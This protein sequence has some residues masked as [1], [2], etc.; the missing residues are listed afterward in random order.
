MKSPSLDNLYA[1]I[2]RQI[3]LTES[4]TEIPGLSF[5]IRAC[6]LKP[7]SY[8]YDEKL[9][10]IVLYRKWFDEFGNSI[11]LVKKKIEIR[12]GDLS[13]RN[14]HVPCTDLYYGLSID[15]IAKMSKLVY[16]FAGKESPLQDCYLLAFLGLDNYLRAYM[17][18]YGEWQR[19]SPLQLGMKNLRILAKN[20]GTKYFQRLE[21]ADN[22]V[23]PCHAGQ[24]WLSFMP[25][26][27][28][29]RVIVNKEHEKLVPILG[30]TL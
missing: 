27:F 24:T 13:L 2:D 10:K 17:Y 15:R 30:K 7:Y 18:L 29:F 11:E 6:R 19:I 3:L 20:R 26:S 9:D 14:K 8:F 28:N 21:K 22:N 4:Y 16:V 12:Y 1:R 5:I 25:T 23:L